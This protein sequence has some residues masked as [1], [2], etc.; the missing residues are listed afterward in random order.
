MNNFY[1]SLEEILK[2]SFSQ[3]E[4]PLYNTRA[5]F[6]DFASDSIQ[7]LS[8][9]EN[10]IFIESN[11]KLEF[12]YILVNGTTYVE[13]YTLDGRRIIADT[14]KAAQI[15]GLIES[16]NS[17]NY[18]KGTVI[19]LSKALLVKINK[20]K[21]LEAVYNDIQISSIIIKYLAYFSTHS[22]MVSEYKASVSPY[23]N[24]IIYLYN[25]VLGKSLPNRINDNKAFIADSLQIN[26]RTLYRYLNKLTDEGIIYREGQE[27]IICK[28][29]F[30]KLE[31][32]FNSI[33]NL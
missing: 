25:K 8:L 31:Q 23:E 12:I 3:E 32:L 10:T 16:I 24:L 26:K 11:K 30:D 14:L 1:N 22:M 7:M 6:K 5:F 27:I 20:D 19:T 33:N 29:N 18:Y 15:F 17:E 13:N 21:F 28:D 2:F 4:K 9:K